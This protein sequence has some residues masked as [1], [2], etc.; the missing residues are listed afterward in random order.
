MPMPFLGFQQVIHAAS[1][2]MRPLM[3]HTIRAETMEILRKNNLTTVFGNPG[4]NELPFLQDF[5]EDFQYILGLHEG[6][7]ISMADGFAQASGNPAFVNLH[8]ASGSGNA[9][10]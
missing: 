9:M 6:A 2:E 4:S 1:Q 7:V 8:A 3:T 10:G 5:P